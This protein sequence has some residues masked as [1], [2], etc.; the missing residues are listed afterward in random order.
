M[1][2]VEPFR[3]FILLIVIVFCGSSAQALNDDSEIQNAVQAESSARETA[4]QW[5]RKSYEKS[6]PMLETAARLW[7]KVGRKSK[8]ANC[9]REAGRISLILSDNERAV[10]FFNQSLKESSPNNPIEQTK[11]LSELSLY[12]L[13]KGDADKSRQ[14]F[15]KAIRLTQQTTNKSAIAEAFFSAAAYYYSQ[16]DVAKAIEFDQKAVSLWQEEKDLR[17]TAK[18][19]LD[20]GYDYLYDSQ[21][22]LGL[23]TF[24][25][26][27]NSSKEIGDVRGQALTHIAIGN[28]YSTIDEKQLALDNYKA[29]ESLFPDDLDFIE[30]ARLFNGIGS[31]LENYGEL[32]ESIIYRE[33]ALQLFEKEKYLYGQLA[34]LSNLANLYTYTDKSEQAIEFYTKSKILA[35]KLHD[36]YYSIVITQDL[37]FFYFKNDLLDK[38]TEQ[39]NQAKILLKKMNLPRLESVNFELIAQI[40]QKKNNFSLAERYYLLSLEANKIVK[41]KFVEAETYYRIS[42]LA[43]TQRK[44]DEA[45][46]S[47][48][49]SIIITENLSSEIYNSH[50][51]S[52]YLSNIF[53]R[54]ELY[55]NLLMKMHKQSPDENFARQAL[56]AAEKSRARSTLENLSLSEANFTKDADAETVKREKEIRVLLNA[57]ADKLTDLLS[58]NAA[59][60]ETDKLDR[61]IN[62]LNNELENIKADLKQKSPV[63]SAIKN[64]APFDVAEFQ[65]DVLDDDSLLLEFSLGKDESYLWLVGKNELSSYV[66]PPRVE[67]ETRV[68]KLRELIASRTMKPDE[69]I[70]DYQKRIADAE[71]EYQTESRELSNQLFGQIGDKFSGKRLIIVPDGKLHYFPAAAL[72]LPNSADDT[73]ILLTNET[74]YEP[75]AAMLALL[76]R[77]GQKPSA[78][79]KN[80]LIFSDPIFSNQDARISNANSS[81]QNEI[82]TVQTDKF[83]FAESLTSLARLN[84]SKDESDS[85]IEIVGE[86]DSTALSGAAATREKA[87]DASIGDYK[88]IHFATH[89]LIK[90]DHPELSG[91]VLSQVDNNGQTVNGVVRL[92]DIY[93][94]NLSADVV[95][96][97]ACSTGIG[98]EVKG[99]GLMS[100]NNAFLQSGAKSVVASLWKVEDNAT[101]ELMKNFYSAMTNDKFTPPQ[102][103]RQA[104]IKLRQNSNYKS[105]FY[106]AAFTVQGDFKI[107]P[108]ISSGYWNKF[109]FLILIPLTLIGIYLYRKRVLRVLRIEK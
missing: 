106:W 95:V 108:N 7:L 83:R 3:V 87:L 40:E 12:Y 42:N 23:E 20:L 84:G 9:L 99:E 54:Y 22:T 50:L 16:R 102:A 10:A 55:I 53:D 60:S 70:E 85:I 43:A 19:L 24:R 73:P 2:R 45:S 32:S 26:S 109:Y 33:K 96:L 101:R 47:I 36:K 27:L 46:I 88:F 58:S 44:Y 69:A 34:T 65:R 89:G 14:N 78:A 39:Y 48:K 76:M 5:N 25:Q 92:Q 105:P 56:Q 64:P 86:S 72:P 100:L 13:Q 104:Q 66:L 31:V 103:L 57:K 107:V 93:A 17:G 79:T 30:K 80:L 51:K 11:T 98:K 49:D 6:I 4:S 38:S 59:K 1:K 97:S 62:E 67:I 74:I 61:E 35:E 91:I 90:E 81:T 68:E 77:N 94:M 21:Y 37:G 28:V 75:S 29:A 71:S 41:D 15:E 8:A 52:T 63:Y 82:G 18:G